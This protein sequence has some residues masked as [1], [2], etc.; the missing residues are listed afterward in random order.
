[1]KKLHLFALLAT[2]IVLPVLADEP[3]QAP[4]DPAPEA[5]DENLM[6]V[7]AN[8]LFEL[9]YKVD[10]LLQAEKKDEAT[11]LILSAL[12]D[13]QYARQ[14]SELSRTIVRFL[15]FTEQRQ[16]AEDFFL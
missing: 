4:E 3:A 1:M 10:D 15:V 14:K 7:D 12:E 5:A 8:P 2:A 6:E 11:D 16:K 9:F 13:P